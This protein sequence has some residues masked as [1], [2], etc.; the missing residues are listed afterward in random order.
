[1]EKIATKILIADG[2]AEL[3]EMI[4]NWLKIEGYTDLSVTE[5]GK[6]AWARL[7]NSPVDLVISADDLPG[8]SGLEL[9]AEMRKDRSLKDTPFLMLAA[10]GQQKFVARAAELKVDGYLVKPFSQ[11][12][13][14]DKVDRILKMWT[15]PPAGFVKVRRADRLVEEGDMDGALTEYREAVRATRDGMAMLHFKIGRVQERLGRDGEAEESYEQALGMSRLYVDTYDALGALAMRHGRGEDAA[16]F[17]REGV[18]ISP[19]NSDRQ[20]RLGEALL[21]TGEI[22]AAEKAFRQS[23]KL[24]PAQTDIFNQLGISL[25]KQNKLDEALRYFEQ[26]LGVAP[27]DEHLYFNAA[28]V[29]YLKNDGQA[30]RPLLAKALE[31]NPGLDEA[32]ELIRQIDASRPAGPK[33]RTPA[34]D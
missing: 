10:E 8:L 30:A 19:L 6:A 13:L 33:D 11:Q 25:R 14:A 2:N 3:R 34:G 16:R 17:F 9:L 23:M 22:E 15:S 1:M 26:A 31:L 7:K 28:Q 4:K 32:R 20:F 24:N 5:N 12:A 29:H 27:N 21:E 18:A